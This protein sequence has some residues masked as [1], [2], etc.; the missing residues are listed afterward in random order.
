MIC[1]ETYVFLEKRIKHNPTSK[2]NCQRGVSRSD[3]NVLNC[4]NEL[5]TSLLKYKIVMELPL[6]YVG[7]SKE[8]SGMCGTFTVL[9]VGVA[10]GKV[11]LQSCKNLKS[12]LC[13]FQR[14]CLMVLSPAQFL[15]KVPLENSFGSNRALGLGLDIGK[16]VFMHRYELFLDV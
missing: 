13:C 10:N 9:F 14:N 2:P 6:E 7:S 11:L 1:T 3:K 4:M 16:C 15:V 8:C 12:A 5:A